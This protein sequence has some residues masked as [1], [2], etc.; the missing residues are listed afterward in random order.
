[1]VEDVAMGV[2]ALVIAVVVFVSG[3]YIGS[4]MELKKA[5]EAQGMVWAEI[6]GDDKCIKVAE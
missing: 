5:C 1:M 3:V 2:F 6:N 4:N